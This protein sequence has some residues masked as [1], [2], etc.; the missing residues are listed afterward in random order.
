MGLSWETPN[1]NKTRCQGF[2]LE[3]APSFGTDYA[4][5]IMILNT[6]SAMDPADIINDS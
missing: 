3:A 4:E 5:I 6:A 2:V 1:D